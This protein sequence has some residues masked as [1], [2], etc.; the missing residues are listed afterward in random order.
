MLL[1]H[2]KTFDKINLNY[3]VINSPDNYNVINSPDVNYYVIEISDD[4][5]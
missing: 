4:C 3:N 5:L 2:Y 1:P